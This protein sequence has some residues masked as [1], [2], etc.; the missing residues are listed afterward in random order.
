MS[1]SAPAKP[2]PCSRPQAP[3]K[4]QGVL[5]DRSPRTTARASSSSDSAMQASTGG[6]GRWNQS[7]AASARVRLCAA[8][9]AVRV[10]SSGPAPRTHSAR[11]TTKSRWSGPPRMCSA[12]RRRYPGRPVRP[13]VSG[14]LGAV[15]V[16]QLRAR[17]L[18]GLTHVGDERQLGRQLV[19][20]HRARRASG[21]QTARRL[22]SAA[23]ELAAGRQL[24]ARARGPRRQQQAQLEG[25][26]DVDH[27][28]R[29]AKL[30]R[31]RRRGQQQ[32]RR[33]DGEHEARA[34]H[35]GSRSARALATAG[36]TS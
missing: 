1:A 15:G 34:Q 31:P 21:E 28:H 20:R 5:R 25:G 30:V 4:R 18:P 17:R 23:H 3:A 12:P 11:P 36:G 10:A 22:G 26:V 16:Q 6:C 27:Q 33:A 13:G 29:G 8:V 7:R 32:Q 35:Q 9:K 2:S 24:E 14:K 19:H